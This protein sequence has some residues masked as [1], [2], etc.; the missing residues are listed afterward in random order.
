MPPSKSEQATR[1]ERID[2]LLEISDWMPIIPYS[3]N[4]P[5]HSEAVTEYETT[6]G[7]A[8][9]ILFD[10]GKALAVVEAMVKSVE[11]HTV[12]ELNKIL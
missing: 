11:N 5:Y 3:V 4:K 8:D 1:K 12:V 9:Y 2:K 7:P 10:Q 6:S